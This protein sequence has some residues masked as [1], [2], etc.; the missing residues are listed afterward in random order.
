MGRKKAKKR[1][2][3]GPGE[4]LAGANWRDVLAGRPVTVDE[5]KVARRRKGRR[6]GRCVSCR[7]IEMVRPGAISTTCGQCGGLVKQIV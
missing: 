2:A 6:P 1:K 5:V 4:Y 3:F 7:R